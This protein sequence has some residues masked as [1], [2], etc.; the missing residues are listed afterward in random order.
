[1]MKNRRLTLATWNVKTLLDNENTFRPERRTALIAAELHRYSM[2][3][4]ALTETRFE[5]E[6]SL[7]EGGGRFTYFWKGVPAGDRRVHGVAFAVCTSLLR[8]IPETPRGISERM[9]MWRV[10]LRN[11]A[12]LTLICVYAPT[13]VADDADKNRF[14]AR[15]CEVTRSV[16]K[17]DKL[18]ILGDLNA[19]LG[20]D[21]QAWVD[22]LGPDG[23][24]RCND[25]GQRLL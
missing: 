19:R 21:C 8:S 25:K 22:A 9:M 13:L 23:I 3:I 11:R 14:Y 2:D 18:V 16:P 1:M 6:D 15:L 7:E 17:N 5:E 12:H 4:A 10:P 20:N 24:G